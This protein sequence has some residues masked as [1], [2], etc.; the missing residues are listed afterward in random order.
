MTTFKLW[1][2]S[3]FYLFLI[4][5]LAYAGFKYSIQIGSK[6]GLAIGDA[7]GSVAGALLGVFISYHL[8]QYARRNGMISRSL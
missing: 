8:F 6:L 1:Q 5:A 3:V 2:V 4:A 7:M